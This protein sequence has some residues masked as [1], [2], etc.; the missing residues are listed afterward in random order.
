MSKT[1]KAAMSLMIVT[2]C[3][4]VLGFVRE[5]V[6]G[7]TYGTTGIADAYVTAMNIPT[8]IF[9]L[10]G[11][12]LATSY[13]PL[14]TE[15]NQNEGKEKALKFSNN[16]LSIVIILGA[17]I[18]ILGIV[19]TQPIVKLFAIGY[20]GEKL[21]LTIQF[22]KILFLSVP[23]IG[24]TYIIKSYLESQGDFITPGINGFP[25][26]I[27]IIITIIL[28]A[29]TNVYVLAWGALLGVMSQFLIQVPS[30]LKRGYKYKFKPNI[31][32]KNLNK[33]LILIAPILVGASINQFNALVDRKLA[34]TLVEGSVSALNYA[35]RL[36][37]FVLG[38]FIVSITAVIYPLLANLSTQNNK[39][40]FGETISTS[41][42][43]VTLLVVPVSA[44]AMI[45]S[46][47]IVQ[48][49]FER[50]AFTSS[51]TEMTSMALICYSLGLLAV[52]IRDVLTKGFYA[53]KDTKTPM[54]NGIIAVIV[55]IAFNVLLIKK[56]EIAGLALATSISGIVAMCLL[57]KDLR[58]KVSNLDEKSIFMTLLKTIISAI[59]MSIATLYTYNTIS[60]IME[61]GKIG[62]ILSLGISVLVGALIYGI[63]I[64][65]LKVDCAKFVID[66]V[67]SKLIKSS[68]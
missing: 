10:I 44:G 55:N 25:Y 49:L 58:K 31:K 3:S 36:N 59:I 50:G 61:I 20:A 8:V 66:K 22:T 62:T 23:F 26:N 2:M 17:I 54:K 38:L 40:K 64:I 29:K 32:D 68:K 45:L 7:A 28:S 13:I 60:S 56:L 43:V 57:Y 39:E 4:K 24:A 34:S 67:K 52:G 37:Q 47:P 15:V 30:S 6:L 42:N 9:A 65:I 1:A 48:V 63:M 14:Y 11:S 51:A 53:L 41:M 35:N 27:I 5:M 16:I 33:M 12:A 18:S 19:F 21:E 46:K